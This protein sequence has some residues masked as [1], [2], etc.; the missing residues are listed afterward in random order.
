MPFWIAQVGLPFITLFS[1]L[2]RVEPMY[3]KESLDIIKNGN[4]NI[5]NEKARKELDFNPRVLKDTLTDLFIWF[6]QNRMIN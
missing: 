3:T 1:W 2:M 6:K 4:K 5:S